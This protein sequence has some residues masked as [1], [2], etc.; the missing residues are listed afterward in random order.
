MEK[1]NVNVKF[2]FYKSAGSWMFILDDTIGM[3]CFLFPGGRTCYASSVGLPA[4]RLGQGNLD[5]CQNFIHPI[6]RRHLVPQSQLLGL[7]KRLLL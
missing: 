4:Q 7:E 5:L 6:G 2:G 1:K 3:T